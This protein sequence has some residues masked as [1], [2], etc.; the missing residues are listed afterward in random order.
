MNAW[1]LRPVRMAPLQ[2]ARICVITSNHVSVMSETAKIHQGLTAAKG[3]EIRLLRGGT[4]GFPG[5]Q[6]KQGVSVCFLLK[7]EPVTGILEQMVWE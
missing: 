5:S 1:G 7:A 6:A 4:S 3:T 2:G